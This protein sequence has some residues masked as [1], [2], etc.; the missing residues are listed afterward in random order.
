MTQTSKEAKD[1]YDEDL[2]SF[3]EDCQAQLFSLLDYLTKESNRLDITLETHNLDPLNSCLDIIRQSKT[4]VLRITELFFQ[5]LEDNVKS[6][7]ANRITKEEI[8]SK[9]QLIS[10]KFF[11]R[12][13]QINELLSSLNDKDKC[14][15]A[16][17]LVVET[18][19]EKE[20][21][22]IKKEMNDFNQKLSENLI[23]VQTAPKILK[24]L[25]DQLEQYVFIRNISP[26]EAEIN[27]FENS[28]KITQKELEDEWNK[29][30]DEDKEREEEEIKPF[31]DQ[32]QTFR[33]GAKTLPYKET[34]N[35]ITYTQTLSIGNQYQDSKIF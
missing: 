30:V 34:R 13:T 11:Q 20:K 5:N 3:V 32:T 35:T 6:H 15:D 27:L 33:L 8:I 1:T 25:N 10:S 17:E 22:Q 31:T 28:D 21:L 4:E 19:F 29:Q 2:S 18:D 12:Q 14:L 9:A 26:K 16:I 7:F 23:E 24:E